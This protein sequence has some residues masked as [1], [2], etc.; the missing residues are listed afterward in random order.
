MMQPTGTWT[1]VG[2]LTFGSAFMASLVL[3]FVFVVRFQRATRSR[4]PVLWDRFTEAPP[5]FGPWMPATS[6]VWSPEAQSHPDVKL[7]RLARSARRS[8]LAAVAF[9]A[10]GLCLVIAHALA[11]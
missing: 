4:D 9:W 2:L 3:A 10:A 1:F 6:Y 7:R 11:G 5:L 8:Y